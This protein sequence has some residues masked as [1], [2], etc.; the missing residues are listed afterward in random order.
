MMNRR[1]FLTAGGLLALAGPGCLHRG[2]HPRDVLVNDV[3]SKLNPTRV[4]RVIPADSLESIQKTIRYA[5][6][7]GRAVSIAGGR[8]A[9]GAQ[10]FGSGT[11]LLD[12]NPLN[13]V[14]H[15]DRDAGTIEV[16]AGIQWPALI[17][18]LLAEQS[19]APHQWGINQK[20]T[21]TDRLGLGGA[22]GT[23]IHG[24][25]L[26]MKPFISDVESFTLVNAEGELVACSRTEN[27][28]LFRLAFGGYGLFGAIYSLKLRLAPR[29]KVRRAVH[30]LHIDEVI[31][32][33]DRYIGEGALYGD[34][35]YATDESSDDY[36]R[37]GVFTCYLPVDPATPISGDQVKLSESDWRGLVYLGHTDKAEAYR[38]YAG[39]YQATAGQ[40]YW[41]DLHQLTT[42]ADDYHVTLDQQLG[43]ATQATEVLTEL[44]VPR[45][46]LPDFM[47]QAAAE[48]RKE[49]VQV[50][51][52]TIRLIERDDESFLAWA[53]EPWACVIF[54]L[55]VVH[56]T[57]GIDH[58]AAAFRRL[59]DLAID[60]R[61]SYY[62]TYHKFATREQV[63][64]CYPQF[65]AF[66]RLK[67]KYDPKERFQSDWYR[68]Y[69]KAF[70]I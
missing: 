56:T 63:L 5:G 23:N 61:G 38:R 53:T 55:H 43:T 39:H 65:P 7:H 27:A 28:E 14:L 8:H 12:T 70:G 32:T 34:F 16:E 17:A 36:L 57:E 48:L 15:F 11:L 1:H 68:H 2:A 9:G 58:A 67:R 4:D 41:S 51:Y 45:T 6:R 30:E 29:K 59:I 52:G 25:G 62:L 13:R 46:S 50:V 33:F 54:N 37:K 31:P 22:I 60:H 19:G 42:Y 20:Q 21:G 69:K 64:A 3:H 44:F 47:A 26:Q 35:Q 18:Y 24:R 66:L 10:Q 49:D 40:V